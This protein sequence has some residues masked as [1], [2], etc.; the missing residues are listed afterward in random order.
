MDDRT[1]F[2]A[3]WVEETP[4]KTYTRRVVA[5]SVGDLPPGELLVR[6]RYSSL[7][8]KDALSASGNHGVT[9]SYPHTPGI[10]A[11]GTVAESASP[12]F[13]PGDEVIVMDHELG[14]SLPGGYGQ[15]VRVPAAWAI[16]LPPGLSLRESM[17]YGTAG[18]TAALSVYKLQQQGVTPDQ[19]EVLVTGATG[20]VGIISVAILAREGFNV[21]AATGKPDRRP[22]LE[23]L[24][25]RQVIHRDEVNDTGEK[26]LLGG[27]WAG[28]VDTVGGNY[29]ATA[30]RATR[31]NGSV[32]TCGN[33]ASPRLD[34]TVYPFILRGV[35]L[36]GIDMLRVSAPLYRLLWWKIA[37]E[38][39]IDRLDDL[40]TERSLDELDPEIERILKGQQVGRVVVNLD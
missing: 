40:V 18:F 22:L 29:L 9:R 35:S 25:A 30:I 8:Y 3:L 7:N 39:K 36:M 19:G 12:A 27:R 28:V 13:R 4:E 20:G 15:Y 23:A 1:K 38:W 24:G 32:T 11:A 31:P 2:T 17:A 6:V 5:R 14:T 33:A 37:R 26:P 34:L 21:V 10:D 16:P